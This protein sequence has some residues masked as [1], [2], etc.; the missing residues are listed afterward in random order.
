MNQ[1][2]ILLWLAMLLGILPNAWGM[3]NLSITHQPASINIVKKGGPALLTFVAEKDDRGVTYQWYQSADGTTATGVEIDG[4]TE[5]SYSTEVF[6]EK[7]IRYYYCVA[8]SGSEHVTSDVVVVAYTGLP[9]LY[10]N[11][12]LPIEDITKEEYVFGKMELVYESGEKFS[13][14]FKKEK[15]G[16]KKEGVKGRGNSSWA[17]PKKGY[18]I[19]F[20]KKQSLFGLPA[21]K[22]WCIIANYADKTLLRNKLA[23]VLGNDIFNSEWNP[24]FISVDVVWNGE[25]QGN[26]LFCERNVIGAG[27]IDIQDIS[28]FSEKDFVDQNKDGV[29]DL[30]DGGFVLEIDK[31]QDAEFAF[32]TTK[33]VYI[34]L[35]D[36]D[37]VS[38]EM[39]NHV[40]G[41]VQNA[42]DVLYSADFADPQNGWRKYFDEESA[43]DWYIIHV[44]A[45]NPDLNY[46]SIYRYFDPEDQKIHFGPIWDFDLGFGNRSA[47]GS[48]PKWEQTSG[49]YDNTWIKRMLL[50][51]TFV[52]K[53]KNR[54]KVHKSELENAINERFQSLA[55]ANRF[56]AECNFMKWKI[57][58]VYVNPNNIGAE[59]RKTYQSEI[60]YM[61]NYMQDRFAWLNKAFENTFFIHYEL[62]GGTLAK[63]NIKFF[64]PERS[65]TFTLNNPTKEGY[66]FAGWSGP[67]ISGVSKKVLITDDQLGDRTFTANWY[68]DIAACEINMSAD[69]FSYKGTAIRPEITITDGDYTLVK[70]T[71]YKISYANNVNTGEAVATIKGKGSYAGTIEK[72]F[73]II[74]NITNYAAIQIIENE[75]GKRAVIN[76]NYGETDAVELTGDITVASV[77]FSR[78]FSTNESATSTLMLPFDVSSGN[79]TGV[80]M[81]LEFDSVAVCRDQ[82]G[83]PLT[84]G[85]GVCVSALWDADQAQT[86]ATLKANTPYMVMM[87]NA[88]LGITGEITLQKTDPI[89]V[90]DKL[91]PEGWRFQGTYVYKVWNYDTEEKPGQI[92]GY[93]AMEQDGAKIGQYV[94]FGPGASLKPFRAYLYNP[95]ETPLTPPKN[96][97]KASDGAKLAPVANTVASVEDDAM[98][99]VIVGR[100]NNG[101]EHTTVIGH[102]SP[103]T[104]Q[105]RLNGEAK[106]TYDLKGRRA[107]GNAKGMYL[108]K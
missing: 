23:S 42:E 47:N 75:N 90:K 81:V 87:N 102:Y 29:V 14:T 82:S 34:T 13:Y 78:V 6:T 35:K 55:D 4:A 74:P 56:S 18:S 92:R 31:R 71:D 10:L 44:F 8:T 106:R 57:L 100:G 3:A 62:D 37:E 33:G 9:I 66:K 46:A 95:N 83:N 27:R 67:G 38:E 107:N 5:S 91:N 85:A 45:P 64:I 101:E 36:P 98:D 65:S 97:P 11:T 93:A 96:A 80:Q 104:G 48:I 89:V 19:K 16:E 63:G 53:M 40:R 60:D 79:L 28:D 61:V 49:W 20:D 99:V 24:S 43:I 15:D 50:D 7:E 39:Q 2:Q 105:I 70:D 108:R 30:Y 22:K 73:E 1:K 58:G 21:S 88:T 41:I 72:T 59:D 54:W 103:R 25:Y 32:I 84:N 94:K 69:D 52:A 86:S 51:S 76:G 77:E 26:Y 68:R 17:M 12:D